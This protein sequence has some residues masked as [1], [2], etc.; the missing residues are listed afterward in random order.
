MGGGGGALPKIFVHLLKTVYIGSIWGWGG[1]GETLARMFWH[2]GVI[3]SG[4]SCPSWG[5]GE[6]GVEV[7]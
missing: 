2:H 3:K 4:T 5:E 7:I 6:G 1:G